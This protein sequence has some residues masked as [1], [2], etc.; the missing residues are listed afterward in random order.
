[1]EIKPVF[2]PSAVRSVPSEN[3]VSSK[4]YGGGFGRRTI[5]SQSPVPTEED[6]A[7]V[8]FAEELFGK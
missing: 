6:D 5:S 2:V 4:K 7:L 1:M 3:A 8:E